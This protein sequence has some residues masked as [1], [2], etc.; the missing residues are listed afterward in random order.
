MW[1]VFNDVSCLSSVIL[2]C[3]SSV[4]FLILIYTYP[5]FP[6]YVKTSEVCLWMLLFPYCRLR[7]GCQHIWKPLMLCSLTISHWQCLTPSYDRS[8]M[9]P[10]LGLRLTTVI[11]R[12]PISVIPML[13]HHCNR[14][15]G[16][17]QLIEYVSVGQDFLCYP[18]PVNPVFILGK[19]EVLCQVLGEVTQPDVSLWVLFVICNSLYLVVVWTI[20]WI[21]RLTFYIIKQR[22][23]SCWRLLSKNTRLWPDSC[24]L[25]SMSPLRNWRWTIVS[26]VISLQ[27]QCLW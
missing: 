21:D 26:N 22:I 1:I 3:K 10:T 15:P 11:S 17:R 23:R 4:N 25:C 7:K 5:H 14:F 9:L 6:D 13:S 19:G 8:C 24:T 12:Q 2:F 16:N 20:Q 27:H 18:N